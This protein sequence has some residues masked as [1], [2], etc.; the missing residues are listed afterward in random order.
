MNSFNIL[1]PFV[2]FRAFRGL[3]LFRSHLVSLFSPFVFFRAFRGLSLFRSHLV[4]LFSPFV[5]FRVFRGL[6]VLRRLRPDERRG[7]ALPAPCSPLLLALCSMLLAL[8][9]QAVADFS[10]YAP[11]IERRPFGEVVIPKEPVAPVVTVQKPPAF[12]RNLRMCAITES[13]AG[14][15]VGFVDIRAKPPKPYYMYLGDEEDGIL[16]VEADF[17][18]ETCMLRKDAE[19]FPMKLGVSPDDMIAE[20]SSETEPKSVSSQ[21]SSHKPPGKTSYAERRRKR[22][23]A[24]RRKAAEARKLNEQEA[25]AALREHQMD[26]IRQGKTPLSIPL[27]QE[28]DD[29]LVREGFLPPQE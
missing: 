18:N 3:S 14:V 11:I 21:S 20:E 29:Q 7:S 24:M 17:N 23:M 6:S 13:A 22:L 27:T 9:S 5:F 8:R 10:R 25:E 28:M 26:L 2:F 4:S 15:R 1:S 16:L 19:Q 12:V